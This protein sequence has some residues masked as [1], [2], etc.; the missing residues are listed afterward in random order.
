MPQ[1]CVASS[2]WTF[3]LF[4]FNTVSC[5]QCCSRI[6]INADRMIIK[7]IQKTPT[8]VFS[9]F[10]L[11][12][13]IFFPLFPL[14]MIPQWSHFQ[15]SLNDP[16]FND[17]SM[18][19]LSTPLGVCSRSWWTSG[20]LALELCPAFP[21]PGGPLLPEER[22]AGVVLGHGAHRGVPG[23]P[24]E[25]GPRA[26]QAPGLDQPGLPEEDDGE[27]WAPLTLTLLLGS[28]SGPQRSAGGRPT[29]RM[30]PLGVWPWRL[31][32]CCPGLIHCITLYNSFWTVALRGTWQTTNTGKEMSSCLEID[33]NKLEKKV[34]KIFQDMYTN[35]HYRSK[36]WGPPDDF[37]FSLKTHLYS[38]VFSSANIIA[39]VFSNHLL[40]F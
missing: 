16:T 30:F 27:R 9:F 4:I 39:Q 25:G 22:C 6:N 8:P 15:W 7:K 18:I 11:F 10:H 23:G 33:Q 32:E 5:F 19:P 29:S 26:L 35:V 24:P 20:G 36:D 2:A 14:S 34:S 17:P 38:T 40:A 3:S 12:F 28:V 13:H 37:M 21:L 1:K 31:S